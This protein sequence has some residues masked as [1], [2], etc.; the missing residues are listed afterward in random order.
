[1][2][3]LPGQQGGSEGS[4]EELLKDLNAFVQSQKSRE[5]SNQPQNAEIQQ[6]IAMQ[7]QLLV[8]NLER[9]IE[10]LQ[11][12]K[13]SINP[14]GLIRKTVEESIQRHRN[15]LIESSA[16][17]QKLRGSGDPSN[18][19]KWRELSEMVERVLDRIDFLDEKFPIIEQSEKLDKEIEGLQLQIRNLLA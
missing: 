13:M 2:K 10:H 16:S 12:Q 15:F 7:R 5:A 4:D 3:K 18:M 6:L 11:S 9:K 1:M 8:Q 14:D 19:A 17:Q